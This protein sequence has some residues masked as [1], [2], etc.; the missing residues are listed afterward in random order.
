MSAEK[1]PGVLAQAVSY[2]L[3]VALTAMVLVGVVSGQA[4]RMLGDRD[5]YLRVTDT[6]IDAQTARVAQAVHETAQSYPFDE[7]AVQALAGKDAVRA[8]NAEVID[9]W[10]GLAAPETVPAPSW[11]EPDIEETVRADEAFQAAVRST[12]RRQIAREGV[13]VPIEKAMNSAVIPLRATLVA[14]VMPK[15]QERVPLARLISLLG[16]VPAACAV[17]AA[18]FAMLIAVVMCRRLSWAL[19]WIGAGLAGGALC[20]GGLVWIV[21]LLDV[22]GQAALVSGILSQELLALGRELAAGM[23]VPA[24]ICA[25]AGLLMIAA[26][27][28][29]KRRNKR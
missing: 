11:S 10:L 24:M 5:M 23:A 17:S 18:V 19:A 7:Q 21:H 3:A 29:G 16:W 6:V 20:V 13:A 9:W 28:M 14:A 27:R 26:S 22:A 8:F 2:L 12:M 4:V 15:V 1:R 25:A